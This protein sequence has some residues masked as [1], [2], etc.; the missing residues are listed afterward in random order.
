MDLRLLLSVLLAAPLTA[1][2]PAV[3]PGQAASP[4]GMD[5]ARADSVRMVSAKADSAKA[6]PAADTAAARIQAA[7]PDS[8]AAAPD[9][10]L[11]PAIA[12]DPRAS[13]AARVEVKA[14]RSVTASNHQTVRDRDLKQ[15]VIMEPSDIL[16]V[17]PG[18]VTSTHAGGGKAN[19][20]FIRGFDADHG[21][22]LAIWVDG[23]PVNNVSHGHGQGYADLNFIIPEIYDRVEVDKGPYNVQYGDFATAG[24]VK[25]ASRNFMPE[26][27]VSLRGGMFGTSRALAVATLNA[28]LK[29]LVAAEVFRYDGP[30]DNPEDLERY[31]VYLKAPMPAGA[32]NQLSLTLMG[33][34]NSWNASGQIPLREVEAGRLSKW[35]T[36]D[37]TDG[38]NS[39]RYSASLDYSSMP[40]PNEQIAI[41]AY[42]IDYNL[43]LY[44][45]FTFFARDSV[46]GDQIN[47]QDDRSVM[48]MNASYRK[49]ASLFGMPTSTLIGMGSRF[50]RIE[51]RLA[52]TKER[53]AFDR[54]VGA[55]TREGALSA[56]VMQTFTPSKW[57]YIEA[58][59]RADLFSFNVEDE[60][61]PLG[62]TS[63]TGAKNASILSP[64]VNVVVTPVAGTDV[65]LNYGEGFHSNDARGII[66]RAAPARPLTKARGYEAGART[67]LFGKLDLAASAWYMDLDGE[68]VWVGDDGGTEE[69]GATT[70]RGLDA[71]AR[72]EILDWLW[73]D[74]DYTASHARYKEDAG[75]GT[76]VALAPTKTLC[77]GLSVAHKSGVHGSLRGQYISDRPATEDESLTAEGYLIFDLGLGWRYRHVEATL[78][79]ANLFDSDW[80]QTQF[81]NESRLP[82]ESGPVADL[83]IVPGTPFKVQG[84]LAYFF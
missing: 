2:V 50:D 56:Y 3:L 14:R 78:N 19:Q 58:G 68:L 9:N 11:P 6:V 7:P 69:R 17:T 24:V 42:Y 28:P 82:G 44:S 1:A 79:I 74:V 38:G 32:G 83:H 62:D 55:L 84:G 30:Y 45:N 72:Y 77:G 29:P 53:V 37:P 10:R 47:Q 26:N 33:Y 13:G 80:R 31:N 35:G 4:A 76:A 73:A 12:S 54:K 5:S 65:F 22:D 34:G 61:H 16:K 67:N 27:M 18:L 81:A 46:M 59:S 40:T 43:S 51:T 66:S 41:S 63:L 20:Y 25:M 21:T 15:R 60:L 23:M 52:Y 71:E 75:G 36:E 8:A 70:R 64:K 39:Q 48:G 57:L 49:R